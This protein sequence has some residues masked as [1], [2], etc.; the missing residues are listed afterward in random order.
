MWIAVSVVGG[1]I[2]FL[3]FGWFAANIRDARITQFKQLLHQE[4]CKRIPEMRQLTA[5]EVFA[6]F[7]MCQQSLGIRFDPSR[8]PLDKPAFGAIFHE[9]MSSAKDFR[10]Q[11][12]AG[13]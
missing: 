3:T 11:G 7:C 9:L 8:R 10:A 2:A 1:L 13:L 5:E 6:L 12:G 4:A